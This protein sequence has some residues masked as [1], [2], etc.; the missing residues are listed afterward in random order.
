[1]VNNIIYILA[2]LVLICWL[3][4]VIPLLGIGLVISKIILVIAAI[5]VLIQL[6]TNRKI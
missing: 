1:M 4:G 2:V 5:L 3:L 6:T